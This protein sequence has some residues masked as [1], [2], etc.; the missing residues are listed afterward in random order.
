MGCDAYASTASLQWNTLHH[1]QWNILT[2][3][4]YFALHDQMK[5][6]QIA[7][8]AARQERQKYQV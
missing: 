8:N 5:Q 6:V 3:Q 7:H 1:R 4:S 2:H